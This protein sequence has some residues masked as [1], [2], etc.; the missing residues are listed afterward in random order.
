M[1]TPL[2]KNLPFPIHW[3][4]AY[5]FAKLGE[6]GPDQV[7][8]SANQTLLPFFASMPIGKE[9]TYARLV[10]ATGMTQ[11]LMVEYER[12]MRF[13]TTPMYA[14]KK[15]QVLY[16]AQG[17]LPYVMGATT[18]MSQLLDREDA[19]AQDLNDWSRDNPIM[20][21]GIPF[22]CNVFFHNLKVYQADESRDLISL[23]SVNL[24]NSVG[25][26]IVEYDYHVNWDMD[27]ESFK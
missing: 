11:P 2:I 12:L 15:E 16:Y 21:D 23:A 17:K 7:G 3:I 9:E 5:L 25:K 22:F 1:P 20:L 26:L 27:Q 18:L 8:V 13:R 6:Y 19:A 4:N 10:E 14:I 24:T